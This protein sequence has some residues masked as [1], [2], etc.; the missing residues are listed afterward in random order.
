M[1]TYLADTHALWWAA[2]EPNRL[3]RDAAR[4]LAESPDVFASVAS[5]WEITIKVSLGKLRLRGSVSSFASELREQG[6]ETLPIRPD[7]VFAIADLPF[8]HRDPFDRLLI[9]QAMREKMTLLTCDEA[10]AAY[11]VKTL[12]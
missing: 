6:I 7:H 2:Y 12:W 8:H 3:G 10:F 1:S 11:G 9:A 5:I 4:V